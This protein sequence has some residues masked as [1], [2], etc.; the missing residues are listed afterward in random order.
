MN[1]I[2]ILKQLSMC[3]DHNEHATCLIGETTFKTFVNH[4]KY[5]C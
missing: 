2:F 1:S 5:E 3:S 4:L